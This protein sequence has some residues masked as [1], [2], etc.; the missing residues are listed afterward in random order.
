VK[1]TGAWG[2]SFKN[3]NPVEAECE[4]Q[5]VTLKETFKKSFARGSLQRLYTPNV[6]VFGF[7]GLIPGVELLSTSHLKNATIF[8]LSS[9]TI[10]YINDC[11]YSLYF[12]K[13]L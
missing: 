8:K 2:Y 10:H 6:Q 13:T 5:E 3:I 7:F 11:F 1:A 12:K 4:E 9:I